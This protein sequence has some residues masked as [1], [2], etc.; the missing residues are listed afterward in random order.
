MAGRKAWR[1]PIVIAQDHPDDERATVRVAR[2][3]AHPAW[4]RVEQPYGVQ[5]PYWIALDSRV[6]GLRAAARGLEHLVLAQAARIAH[7]EAERLELTHPACPECHDDLMGIVGSCPDCDV[8][9]HLGPQDVVT[10]P[11]AEERTHA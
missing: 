1:D 10:A 9:V 2:S 8:D 6:G 4:T 7:L 5:A 11:R 3:R